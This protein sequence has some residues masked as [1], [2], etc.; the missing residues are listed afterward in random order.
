MARLDWGGA[1]RPVYPIKVNQQ[2]SVVRAILSAGGIGLEAGSKPEL[3]AVL[4]L[5]PDGETVVCNGYKDR[6]YIRL[7]LIGRRLGL[8]GA[9]RHREALGAGPG[10]R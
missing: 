9:H 2:K 7:A 3:M 8:R 4:A 6:D 5:A 1:Y 10:D